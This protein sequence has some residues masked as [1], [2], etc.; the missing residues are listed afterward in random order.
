VLQLPEVLTQGTARVCLQQL[1]AALAAEP[2]AVLVDA[3]GLK[4]FD[5]A[6][7]A[8]LLSLRRQ[9]LALGKSFATLNL[10][11]RLADLARLY[12]I[13]SLLP[14]QPGGPVK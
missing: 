6:A 7:L 14:A 1:G 3:A 11:Q 4:R 8:L 2:A 9:A 12:G 10:P 13:D 5:S